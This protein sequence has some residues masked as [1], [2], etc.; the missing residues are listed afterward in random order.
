M[1]KAVILVALI[2]LMVA[3]L[4]VHAMTDSGAYAA[5][6]TGK[7]QMP[8]LDVSTKGIFTLVLHSNNTATFNMTIL[9][10]DSP[11]TMAHIHQGNKTT[12]GPPGVLLLPS[13]PNPGTNLDN[14]PMVTP[15][16][17]MTK[18]FVSATFGISDLVPVVY[19]QTAEGWAAF[20]SDLASG[21]AY[22]NYH[23]VNY[24]GGAAR[25]QLKPL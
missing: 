24:P 10:T 9:T 21:N 25:G 14:L 20:L 1:T 22:V 16:V 7:K 6:L 15:P 13:S 3:S 4:E 11:F 23:T 18:G 19:A 8:P 2:S 5:A 12:N 17:L